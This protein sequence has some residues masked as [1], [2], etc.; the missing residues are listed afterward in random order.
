MFASSNWVLCD[1]ALHKKARKNAQNF[2]LVYHLKIEHN[3]IPA[4]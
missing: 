4:K 1:A 2:R 3:Q